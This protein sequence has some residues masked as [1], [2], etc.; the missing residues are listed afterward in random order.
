MSRCLRP[1]SDESLL[2]W[3]TGELS[4]RMGFASRSTFSPA[5]RARRVRT[6]CTRSPSGITG[7]VREGELTT[8][9][10]PSVVGLLRRE[11]RVIREYEVAPGRGSSARS[12]E[13][14]VVLARLLADLRDVGRLDLVIRVD[15]GA[16][17]RLSDLPFDPSAGEVILAPVD[18]RPAGAVGSRPEAAPA[19]SWAGGREA[20]RRLHLQP[21][22]P[23]PAPLA[24]PDGYRPVPAASVQLSIRGARGQRRA[25]RGGAPARKRTSL[26]VTRKRRRPSPGSP[27]RRGRAV[28][29]FLT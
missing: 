27:A 21:A 2:G 11:G 18:P 9:V 23:G 8:V 1:A 17:H 13:D 12:S 24:R 22:R 7:L 5:M 25:G 4:L 19:G 28:D 16:E 20:P 10:L 6:S 15:E 3:W 29:Y 26:V 14:D